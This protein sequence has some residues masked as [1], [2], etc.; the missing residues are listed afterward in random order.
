M[1]KCKWT[2]IVSSN[3]RTHP[4][5]KSY[6]IHKYWSTPAHNAII[7]R[8]YVAFSGWLGFPNG[9]NIWSWNVDLYGFSRNASMQSDDL[10]IEKESFRDV[11]ISHVTKDWPVQKWVQYGRRFLEAPL[12][13]CRE[14][15]A[16]HEKTN[17]GTVW[18]AKLVAMTCRANLSKAEGYCNLGKLTSLRILNLHH[19]W[20]FL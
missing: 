12:Y 7:Y 9:H 18:P 20:R 4:I 6:N 8:L 16:D 1:A 10:S 2:Q 17:I 15:A 5:Y 13:N 11:Q 14:C 19:K 3:M